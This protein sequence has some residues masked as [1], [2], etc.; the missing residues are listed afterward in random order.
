MGFKF[1]FP[2]KFRDAF[3]DTY[4]LG[5]LGGARNRKMPT[6]E[7]RIAH[8]CKSERAEKRVPLVPCNIF[9]SF[10]SLFQA[11]AATRLAGVI[12]SHIVAANLAKFLVRQIV[13]SRCTVFASDAKKHIFVLCGKM[14]SP[15]QNQWRRSVAQV[16]EV[17]TFRRAR[18]FKMPVTSGAQSNAAAQ[19]PKMG[20]SRV[21]A[22]AAFPQIATI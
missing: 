8:V 9:P 21:Q 1:H 18:K 13:L 5:G 20:A 10:S 3:R 6:R 22:Q 16:S 12:A 7:C 11:D 2:A 17:L 4:A 15:G 19:W 14:F